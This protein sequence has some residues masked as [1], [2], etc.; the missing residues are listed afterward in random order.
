MKIAFIGSRGV[1][2]S[3]G[4][5]ETFVD[6]VSIGLKE[7]Y[8]YSI[9]VVGD[10]EQKQKHNALSEYKGIQLIYSRFNKTKYPNLYYLDS[11]LLTIFKADIVYCC[12]AGG[13]LS[14]IIPFLL[15]TN[16]VTNPDGVGWYRDKWS[17]IVKKILKFMF[18]L[19]A[20]LSK[21]IVNDSFG[22]QEMMKK[23][24]NRTKNSVTIEY[25]AYPN[26]FLGDSKSEEVPELLKEYKL[27]SNCYHLVVAR[28]EP[29]NNVHVIIKGY[30]ESNKK[31]PLVVIGGLKDTPYV[32]E[33]KVL[34]QKSEMVWLIGGV[35]GGNKLAIIRANAIDYFHGHSVGGTN[36]SLL[37]AMASGNLCVCHNN[38]FNKEV[39]R[40]NGFYF[41]NEKEVKEVVNRIEANLE[42]EDILNNRKGVE[43][44]FESYFTWNNIVERYHLY[45]QSIKK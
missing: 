24:F 11:I 1:P 31:F 32:K 34:A 2:A 6:E 16:F 36:P 44:R 38:P 39:V 41:N 33:L 35:Y 8:N 26:P 20:R 17:P 19:T 13:A 18:Y 45:F 3:Y 40:E 29:E 5:F 21:H 10:T 43:N 28:L 7:K 14:F 37:E 23:E 12:G 15:R 42:S 4:G 22:I 9:I 27:T 30:L 25:G